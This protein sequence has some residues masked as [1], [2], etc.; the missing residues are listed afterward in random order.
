MS[1]VREPV[2]PDVISVANWSNA[3]KI[4]PALG[5]K[6]EDGC[7]QAAL[8]ITT[9]SQRNW[10]APLFLPVPLREFPEVVAECAF[11]CDLIHKVKNT[12][13]KWWGSAKGDWDTSITILHDFSVDLSAIR[14][15]Q[16]KEA[17]ATAAR[18]RDERKVALAQAQGTPAASKSSLTKKRASFKKDPKTPVMVVSDTDDASDDAEDE[19][20][21]VRMGDA[22]SSTQ[23]AASQTTGQAGDIPMASTAVEIDVQDTASEPAAL[24]GDRD[25]FSGSSLRRRASAAA[26][27]DDKNDAPL[28]RR[29]GSARHTFDTHPSV[30]DSEEAR[31]T[32][33]LVAAAIVAIKAGATAFYENDTILRMECH[34]HINKDVCLH[35]LSFE[36]RLYEALCSDH[37]AL[38]RQVT[39]RGL[40]ILSDDN[41]HQ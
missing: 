5:A 35:S 29:Y 40:T 3:H 2:R 9:I 4:N 10:Y 37:I 21:D 34:T 7:R 1:H 24:G 17:S 41:I 28:K 23:P 27:G 38:L 32:T 39:N 30:E 31:S 33:E 14:A 12:Y 13:K 16:D 8:T 11:L 26:L 15:T 36:L 22:T 20:E 6:F 18:N 25:S 19:G